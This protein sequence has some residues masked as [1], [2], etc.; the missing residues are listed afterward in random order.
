MTLLKINKGNQYLP[1]YEDLLENLQR[2]GV[3]VPVTIDRA[4]LFE[5]FDQCEEMETEAEVVDHLLVAILGVGET[6]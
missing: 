2:S 6:P 4:K 5:A 1:S 3:L